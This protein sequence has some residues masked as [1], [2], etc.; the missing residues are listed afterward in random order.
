MNLELLLVSGRAS[1]AS[2][3]DNPSRDV[4]VMGIY[5]EASFLMGLRLGNS[6]TE[7]SRLRGLEFLQEAFNC[8]TGFVKMIYGRQYAYELK[9]NGL[10]ENAKRLEAQMQEMFWETS[11]PA[12]AEDNAPQQR[13]DAQM[14]STQPTSER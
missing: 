12:V 9:F 4:K 7:E 1:G 14:E 8:A 3:P 6:R 5:A 10:D 13:L 11:I 2:S